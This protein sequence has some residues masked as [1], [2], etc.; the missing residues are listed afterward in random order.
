MAIS[1]AN[2]I[3]PPRD[4]D[5]KMVAAMKAAAE[6][7]ILKATLH[8]LAR[9]P[10]R[11]ITTDAIAGLPEPTERQT[12]AAIP[13]QFMCAGFDLEPHVVAS[14]VLDPDGEP[15]LRWQIVD[16]EQETRRAVGRQ[17]DRPRLDSE[18]LSRVSRTRFELTSRRPGAAAPVRVTRP[19]QKQHF[20]VVAGIAVSAARSAETSVRHLLGL[21]SNPRTGRA[22]QLAG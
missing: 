19:Q 3:M 11:R 21:P 6:A 22:R 20:R 13:E 2:A 14:E 4:P 5:R 18:T 1:T 16:A 9:Q 15:V 17:T 12:A 7:A 8:L 10:L